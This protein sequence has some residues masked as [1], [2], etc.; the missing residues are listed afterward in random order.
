MNPYLL[1]FFDAMDEKNYDLML[2][3]LA[4]MA[5]RITQK[6]LDDIYMVFDVQPS[7]GLEDLDSQVGFLRRHILMLKK[8]DGERLR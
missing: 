8:F 1:D 6:E 2:E 3:Y 5:K 4:K 7:A